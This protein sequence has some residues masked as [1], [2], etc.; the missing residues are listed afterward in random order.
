[1]R[2]RITHRTTYTYEERVT[3]CYNEAHLIPR[4][5]PHQRCLNYRVDVEPA[6]YDRTEREDFFGNRVLYFAIEEPHDTLI[7]TATSEVSLENDSVQLQFRSNAP[8]QESARRLREE[9]TPANLDAVQ[10]LLDSPMAGATP[11]IK[12]YAA[13]PFREQRPLAEIVFDLMAR[14]HRDFDYDPD[15]TTLAT[16]LSEVLEHR[17]GVCQDFAHL[18]IAC[19]RSHGVPARYVSGYIETLPPPGQVK[20]R[21]ADASH[22]W[23]SAYDPHVGWLDYD[24]TNNQVPMGRHITTAWGRD[25]SDITPLKGVIYGGGAHHHAQVAV[26][27]T[28]LPDK[29]Y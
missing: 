27:V 15:F 29:N 16:P 9:R 24:P 5:G 19:L 13:P 18:A 26:D 23:F 1:M 4:N 22:A 7:T 6:P 14:I 10:Y 20:L 11:R 21:G 3:S 12:R 8:W 25:Y 17:R 2:Y 28:A